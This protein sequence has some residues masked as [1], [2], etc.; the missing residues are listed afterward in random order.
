MT[1]NKY[2][3]KRIDAMEGHEFEH[4]IATLLRSLGYEKVEVTP[5]SGD[6]GVD[7]LA[8]KDGVRYAI[9]CKCYSTDLGNTPVQ[10]V[11]TG[12]MV[13][14]CH[15]GVVVTN[16]Y[17]TQSAREAA[18]ATGVLLW[19]RSKLEKL[20][21]QADFEVAPP[22]Q[23]KD[24][25]TLWS[26]SPLLRRG[27][28]ALKDKEWKKATHFFDRV[29]NTDPENA[30]AYLGLMM[31]AVE[32]SDQ[33]TLAQTYIDQPWRLRGNNFDHMK[34]FAGPELSA[35]FANLDVQRQ[36]KEEKARAEYKRKKEEAEAEL[37]RKEAEAERR[38]LQEAAERYA[39]AREQEQVECAD[40]EPDTLY[41]TA[42]ILHTTAQEFRSLGS[43]W[44][45]LQRAEICEQ[46][47]V[48]LEEEAKAVCAEQQRHQQEKEFRLAERKIYKRKKITIFILAIFVVAVIIS[49][50]MK[51]AK[52]AEQAEQEKQRV[53]EA[54]LSTATDFGLIDLEVSV[55]PW[56]YEGVTLYDVTITSSN[57]NQFSYQEMIRIENRLEKIMGVL[58]HYVCGDDRYQVFTSDISDS[59]TLNG[60]RVYDNYPKKKG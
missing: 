40:R 7:V 31:A 53:Y 56:Q 5:G 28:I 27:G 4:F 10:E 49:I 19:D 20:I 29:L 41:A 30:E 51:L 38:W 18:K 25:L 14:Q 12:K 52:E 32:L 6:Q 42:Q 16:R 57:F 47:A 11:N 54:V 3:M 45:S 60:E 46:R 34:E 13:Y 36:K 33:S 2:D 21:S 26:G 58:P 50:G 1:A 59:V 43:Y 22:K 44:D 17:F 15:V 8:E 9:Q 48:C 55:R 37:R 23:Q 24:S 35:W 39:A